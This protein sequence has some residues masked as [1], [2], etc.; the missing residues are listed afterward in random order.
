M[1]TRPLV[2]RNLEKI[3]GQRRQ[4]VTTPGSTS[5]VG[6]DLRSAELQADGSVEITDCEVDDA[7]VYEVA[8]GVVV[9]DD[10]VTNLII[11]DDGQ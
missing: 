9:N 6:Q 8:T 1:T 7:I 10:V 11:A 5:Q 3:A 4:A 2:T